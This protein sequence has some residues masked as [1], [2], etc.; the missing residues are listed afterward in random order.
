MARRRRTC[1]VTV[2]SFC[3]KCG[4]SGLVADYQLGVNGNWKKVTRTAKLVQKCLKLVLT[5]VCPFYP[6]LICNLRDRIGKKGGHLFTSDDAAFTV[7]TILN[8]AKTIQQVQAQ[9]Q[10]LDPQEVLH[11]VV[12]V[13]AAPDPE[14]PR[15]MGI[16]V[17][18]VAAS[19][20]KS[21]MDLGLTKGN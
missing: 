11:N 15:V 19:G 10:V 1:S 21:Q 3:K 12:Q 18:I 6:A 20:T 4:A 8:Q 17:G 7:S 9:Y 2:A 5:S 13:Q 16:S 14:D